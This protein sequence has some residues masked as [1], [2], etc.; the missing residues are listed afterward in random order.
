MAKISG[1]DSIAKAVT[2]TS[3]T[4]ADAS[5]RASRSDKPDQKFAELAG[6]SARRLVEIVGNEP[7]GILKLTD[8]V[9]SSSKAK[10]G[11]AL[12]NIDS[13][14]KLSYFSEEAYD[15]F[16]EEELKIPHT[17]SSL[18]YII[19]V[20]ADTLEFTKGL[21]EF[22]EDIE[23]IG[24]ARDLG[25]LHFQEV[26]TQCTPS[27]I[28]GIGSKHIAT[29]AGSAPEYGVKLEGAVG[30]DALIGFVAPLVAS[31][32]FTAGTCSI[33]RPGFAKIRKHLHKTKNQAIR[34]FLE[35]PLGGQIQVPHSSSGQITRR[36]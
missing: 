14:L 7:N 26:A 32:V 36:R 24:S 1:N 4:V 21:Q 12:K 8:D 15:R 35:L 2:G 11:F 19:A 30:S 17:S 16:I 20:A 28:R 34:R 31:I 22:S 29:I 6:S 33:L 25:G 9:T 27:D 23:K 10:M 5:E 13:A 3:S 18:R